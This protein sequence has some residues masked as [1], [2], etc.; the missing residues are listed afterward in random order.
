M[1]LKEINAEITKLEA[2]GTNYSSCEKLACLYTVRDGL[3]EKEERASERITPALYSYAASAPRRETVDSEQ[4]EFK[5]AAYSAGMDTLVDVI[6]EHMN[7]VKVIYPKEY[8]AVVKKLKE[9]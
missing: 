2:G 8:E 3:T 5:K 4:S 1:D 6:D 7:A 9:E